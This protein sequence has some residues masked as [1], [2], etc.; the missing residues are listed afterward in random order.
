ML[1]ILITVRCFCLLLICNTIQAIT[2]APSGNVIKIECQ[3]SN[4]TKEDNETINTECC[5]QVVKQYYKRWSS[6][7]YL[8]SFLEILQRRNCPQFKRECE[9]RT[10]NFTDFTSLMYLRFC[11]R[12]QMEEQCY[13]DVQNIV[14]KQNNR[15]QTKTSTYDELVSKLNLSILS[16]QDLMNPCVQIAMYNT[17]ERDHHPY[18][19]VIN[20]RVPFC[21]AVWGGFNTNIASSKYIAVWNCMPTR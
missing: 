17:D 16:D 13:N 18:F 21:E 8:S 1:R 4:G 14:T 5:D 6:R 9:R 10:F 2:I 3:A 20:L 7:L 12:S 19:E 15:I 11:N